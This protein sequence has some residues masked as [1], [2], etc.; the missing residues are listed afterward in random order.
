MRRVTLTKAAVRRVMAGL[1]K[2][3][4]VAW[5][6][7]R[8]W[9]RLVMGGAMPGGRLGRRRPG[10]EVLVGA[11]VLDVDEADFQDCPRYGMA[12][13]GGARY[14]TVAPRVVYDAARVARLVTL[15]G[16]VVWREGRVMTAGDEVLGVIAFLT[17]EGLWGDDR[18]PE[19][20]A[21]PE[22]NPD[23]DYFPKEVPAEK[24]VEVLGLGPVVRV[25][26]VFFARL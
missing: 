25:G 1:E 8:T 16:A 17:P 26:P 24:V 9:E 21:L 10:S 7:V 23:Y 4:A 11:E 20:R 2:L 22:A 5:L 3:P 13:G 6:S 15:S 18:N 14:W 19:W 12:A